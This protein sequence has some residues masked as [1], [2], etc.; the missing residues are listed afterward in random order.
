MKHVCTKFQVK[1]ADLS[2]VH[3]MQS[4]VKFTGCSLK[5]GS[6]GCSVKKSCLRQ[7]PER[8]QQSQ[9]KYTGCSLK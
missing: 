4:Q 8:N 9:V 1:F 3:W 2:K 7:S 6:L 5:Q